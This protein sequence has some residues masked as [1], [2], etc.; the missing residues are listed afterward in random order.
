MYNTITI[1]E[2]AREV[3]VQARMDVGFARQGLR[4]YRCRVNRKHV[5]GTDRVEYMGGSYYYQ[6]TASLETMATL[7]QRFDR[8]GFLKRI[9]K[10]IL[11]HCEHL[12][13]DFTALYKKDRSQVAEAQNAEFEARLAKIREG[14]VPA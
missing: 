9:A 5:R 8:V 13:R 12:E 3:L 14:T 1:N 6:A 4:E 11:K 2:F 10:I 7:C